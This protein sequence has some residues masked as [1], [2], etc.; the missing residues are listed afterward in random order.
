[1]IRADG[2]GTGLAKRSLRPWP[3]LALVLAPCVAALHGALQPKEE[4]EEDQTL[5]WW[6]ITKTHLFSRL[7]EEERVENI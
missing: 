5:R 1:M 7:L 6:N 4:K 3:A 2:T